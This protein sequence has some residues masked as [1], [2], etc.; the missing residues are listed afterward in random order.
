[1]PKLGARI[2]DGKN[3]QMIPVYQPKSGKFE[4]VV[5]SYDYKPSH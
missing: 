5:F 3:L 4:Q 2:T 1:M